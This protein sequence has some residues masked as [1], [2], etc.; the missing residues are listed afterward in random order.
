[1]W[2]RA[3]S[4]LPTRPDGGI[5]ML[6][7]TVEYALRAVVHLA[8]LNGERRTVPQI[9]QATD[10]PAGYLAK[11]LQPLVRAGI[12][13][14]RRGLGG[15]FRLALAPAEITILDVVSAVEPLRRITR[16]PLGRTHEEGVLCPLHRTLDETIAHTEAVFS[17][18]T[19]ADML[20]GA[21]HCFVDAG[22]EAA[23]AE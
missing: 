18:A 5:Y 13:E 17:K 7:Q 11:V 19:L 22:D 10:T 12:V 9:A 21:D 4:I 23:S 20:D 16:C 1:M 2:W 6:S 8:S 3:E 15:G 14:S